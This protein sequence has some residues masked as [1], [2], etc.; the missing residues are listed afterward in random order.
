MEK[1]WKPTPLDLVLSL[2]L[3]IAFPF[4]A[5]YL[6]FATGALMP[7]ILYYGLAWGIW[8]WR[9][10]STV[11]FIAFKTKYPRSFFVNVGVI[12][13]SLICAYFARIISVDPNSTGVILTAVIWA[14]I[15]AASE[16]LLWIYIFESWDLYLP[17]TEENK[18]KNW[19]YR[20][21]G[22]VLFSAFVGTIH[23]M[24]WVNFLHTV[25]ATMVIGVVFVLLTT[26]SG[27]LHLVVWREG[28]QMILTFI[29]H[30]LL[31]LIPLFW[32]GYSIFPY[33]LK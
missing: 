29:P 19:V 11:Y 12:L 15:N 2:V 7:M 10:G 26:V 13:L 31:N 18:K 20:A 5:Q 3:A 16:Q 14:T 4:I 6:Y 1:A 22:L 23:T 30:F 17:W 27:Y 8:K 33:L 24:Y 25:D 28:N 9:R 32:T 21:I